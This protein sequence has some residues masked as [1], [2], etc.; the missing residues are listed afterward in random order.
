MKLNVFKNWLYIMLFAAI[1]SCKK[2]YNP[3]AISAPNSYLVVEG[4]IHGGE[5]S[6]VITLSR[7]VNVSSGTTV[8]PVTGALVIVESSTNNSY[9]LTEIKPGNY[10]V[11]PITLDVSAK[12]RL[13]ITINNAVYLSDYVAV[14]NAPPVDSVNYRIQATGL[15]IYASTHDPSNNTQYYRWDYQETW[16]IYSNYF[17]QYKSNGDTV[18]P[19]N[20]KIDEIYECWKTDTSS[21]IILNSSAKLSKSIIVN[22]PIAFV[23]STSEKLSTEYSILVREYALTADAYNFWTNLKKNTEQLGSIFDAEPSQINGNIHAVNNTSEPVIGYISAGGTTTLRIFVSKPHLP[24]SWL[25]PPVYTSCVLDTGLYQYYPPTG[26]GPINQVNEL[27]NYN[28]GATIPLI[29]VSGIFLPTK[30]DPIG[31]NGSTPTCVDCTL[32]GTNKRPAFWQD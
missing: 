3:P 23:P 2:P 12:Y 21:T 22:N 15:Q 31:Y 13:R 28:R 8:N 16:I 19:R 26:G 1:A 29:P 14:L 18:L 24:A 11:S 7:T 32:R 9:S 20:N 17:S 27:F 30:E 4:V 6:T 5:D 10:S 25:A